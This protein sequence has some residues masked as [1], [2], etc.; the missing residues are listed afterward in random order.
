V[1]EEGVPVGKIE[2]FVVKDPSIKS[3][4]TGENED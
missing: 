2:R 4:L 3:I 1:S